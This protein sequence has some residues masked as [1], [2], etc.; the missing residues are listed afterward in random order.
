MKI[1]FLK[2]V[3]VDYRVSGAPEVWP[4]SFYRGKEVSAKITIEK[5]KGYA[6]IVLKNDDELLDVPKNAFEVVPG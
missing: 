1:K 5:S 3:S 6:D 2:T 4:K